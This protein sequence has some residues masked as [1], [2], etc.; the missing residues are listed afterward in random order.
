MFTFSR[1]GGERAGDSIN[2][3]SGEQ[4][5]GFQRIGFDAVRRSIEQ[6]PDQQIINNSAVVS[7]LRVRVPIPPEQ[8]LESLADDGALI[9]TPAGLGLAPTGG[10]ALEEFQDAVKD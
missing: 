1:S 4:R 7:E 5:A 3:Y 2:Q 9:R 6:N 10:E 8:V